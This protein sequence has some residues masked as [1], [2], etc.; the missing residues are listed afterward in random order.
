[1][2]L[3]ESANVVRGACNICMI[4]KNIIS[5]TNACGDSLQCVYMV[6]M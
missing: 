6:I 4:G 1:M 5:F 3:S 2:Q